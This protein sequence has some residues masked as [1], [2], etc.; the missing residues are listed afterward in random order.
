LKE[1]SRSLF[2]ESRMRLQIPRKPS[3]F[4]SQKSR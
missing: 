4:I 3:K 1:G 2:Q